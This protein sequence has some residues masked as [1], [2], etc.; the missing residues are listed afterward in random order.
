MSD[1]FL[2][3][4]ETEYSS[5]CDSDVVRLSVV[6]PEDFIMVLSEC[7][8]DNLHNITGE[9]LFESIPAMH[10][11]SRSS[12]IHHLQR[13]LKEAEE[14]QLKGTKEYQEQQKLRDKEYEAAKAKRAEAAKKRKLEKAKKLLEEE[15]LLK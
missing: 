5:D 4:A 3:R 6:L 12:T 7:I 10:I 9:S 15:G 8:V 11:W 1:F 14:I 2:L 13:I